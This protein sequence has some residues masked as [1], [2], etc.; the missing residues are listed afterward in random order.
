MSDEYVNQVLLEVNGQSITDF[1]SVSEDAIVLRKAVK[2]MNK[3]G[4]ITM[5]PQYGVKVEYVVPKN[6]TPFDFAAVSGGTLTIDYE[7]GTRI[8]YTGVAT[9]EIGEIK[10]DG[11]NEATQ[12]ISF[13]AAKRSS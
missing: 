5:T 6:A 13:V 2:L 11:E 10:Y 4:V 1:K 9:L 3:T 8:K 7:N 12:T